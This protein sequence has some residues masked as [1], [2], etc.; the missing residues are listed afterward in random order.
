MESDRRTALAERR[1]F[2][3]QRN[4]ARAFRDD[5]EPAWTALEA[6]RETFR[7]Y[8]IGSEPQWSPSW[9]PA[10]YSYIPWRE[11]EGVNWSED[12]LDRAAL[13][14][15]LGELLVERLE[16]ADELLFIAEGK[17]WSIGTA[18]DVFERHA[19]AL[20]EA[21][22]DRAYLAAPPADWLIWADGH[23]LVW[24]DA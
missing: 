4:A 22:W 12:G 13:A 1:R 2:M 9:V 14:R 10:G 18:R 3:Q 8:R 17:T 23:R 16:A 21:A 20:L 11:L 24:K 19:P 7:A 15:L 6:A 5:L